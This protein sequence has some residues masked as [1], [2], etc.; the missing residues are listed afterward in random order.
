MFDHHIYYRS[1]LQ[2]LYGFLSTLVFVGLRYDCASLPYCYNNLTKISGPM[3][4]IKQCFLPDQAPSSGL[5]DPGMT[6]RNGSEPLGYGL[7]TS[8]PRR[9]LR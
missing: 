6:V 5:R 9:S 4:I 3:N 7:G 2:D 8:F 1:L